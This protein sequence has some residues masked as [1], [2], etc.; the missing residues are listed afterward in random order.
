MTGRTWLL[1]HP[2]LL[3]PAVLQPLAA[4][5]RRR[6]SAVAVPDL[7]GA[8]ATA[9]G[10]PERW[11]EGAAAAGRAEVVVGFSGAGIVLPAVAAAAGARRVV[12]LDAVL[13]TVT[14][15]E[16]I[17]TLTAPLVRD[18]RIADWT[19]WWGPGAMAELVP[20]ERLRA[21]LLAEGHE[22]PADFYDVAVPVPDRWPDDDVR[23]VHLSASYDAEAT[24]ARARG[25]TVV[26]DGTGQ[27]LDVANEPRRVADL[28]G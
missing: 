22:L 13:P 23:Y 3:G 7:R 24:A 16:E 25:W 4:E 28:F 11:V 26:G 17:R 9:P 12:W 19:T 20:D 27:H 18:G 21:A 1:V 2:P 5:L 10:W 15:S 8:V 14:W 6:G